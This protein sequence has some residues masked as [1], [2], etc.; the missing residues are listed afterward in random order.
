LAAA[1]EPARETSG[2]FYD[3]IRLPNGY[4]GLLVAD[5][6]DKGSG[7]AIYMALSRTLIRTYA[8]EYPTQPARALRAA[9]HRILTDASA[10]LFVTVFY[11]VL[12]PAFGTFTYCNA[13]HN[14]PYLWGSHDANRPLA[15]TRTGLPLGILEEEVWGERTVQLDPGSTLVLYTDGVTD[16]ENARGEFFAE[17]RLRKVLQAQREGTAQEILDAVRRALGDFAGDAPRARNDDITLMVLVREQDGLQSLQI[18]D[19][20]ITG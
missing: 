5:V 11:G 8:V 6:A 9:N 2:D 16:V 19:D 10:D 20:A 13:G 4:W 17:E 18:E 12:D 1:L 7:A 14:P 15:L 3:V